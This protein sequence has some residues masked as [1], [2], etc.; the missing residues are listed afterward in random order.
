MNGAGIKW[1]EKRLD[2][3]LARRGERTL[4]TLNKN[5]RTRVRNS[6][7]IRASNLSVRLESSERLHIKVSRYSLCW[8]FRYK[9][10]FRDF[11]V[12]AGWE[13]YCI[14]FSNWLHAMGLRMSIFA[15]VLDSARIWTYS[16]CWLDS[17]NILHM[18][19]APSLS[20]FAVLSLKNFLAYFRSVAKHRWALP[21]KIS[22]LNKS[23]IEFC[24]NLLI[25]VDSLIVIFPSDAIYTGNICS[26]CISCLWYF[27]NLAHFSHLLFSDIGLYS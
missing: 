23:L 13:L 8:V 9:I 21:P 26:Y 3:E 14:A 18:R 19:V 15:A 5:D 12:L 2:R 24:Q 27:L 11:F 20:M 25:L 6:N 10:L 7:S 17:S 4:L 22:R 1:A 16:E